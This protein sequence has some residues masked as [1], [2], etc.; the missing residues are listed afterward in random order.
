MGH[1]GRAWEAASGGPTTRRKT[2]LQTGLST[3]T[4][5]VFTGHSSPLSAHTLLPVTQRGPPRA[6]GTSVHP[7]EALA[8]V[9]ISHILPAPWRQAATSP[10]PSEVAG[11]TGAWLREALEALVTDPCTQPSD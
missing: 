4:C 5:P 1:A 6:L 9:S 7:T 2:H 11:N 10:P 8:P 3:V